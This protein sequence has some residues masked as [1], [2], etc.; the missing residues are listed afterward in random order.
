LLAPTAPILAR[1][2]ADGKTA[3]RNTLPRIRY[4][5]LEVSGFNDGPGFPFVLLGAYLLIDPSSVRGAVTILSGRP[6]IRQR[7]EG[8]PRRGCRGAVRGSPQTVRKR[9]G[10]GE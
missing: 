7:M 2:V 10:K 1:T 9:A 3:S 5:L 4:T 8:R 6:C